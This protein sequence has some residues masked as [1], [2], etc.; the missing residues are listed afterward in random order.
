MPP[1]GKANGS[2]QGSK[3]WDAVEKT[4]MCWMWKAG[5]SPKGYGWVK[6][7]GKAR[8]AHR[9]AWELTY[10]PIPQRMNVLHRCDIPACVRPDHLFLGTQRD[11]ILDAIEKGRHQGRHNLPYSSGDTH[12]MAKLSMA[13]VLE[14]RRLHA[15]GLSIYKLAQRR[16]VSWTTMRDAVRGITWK[17]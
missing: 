15:Q 6:Y 14:A 1:R 16:S 13:I 4:D 3:F 17:N 8:R 7:R 10:G 11:N 2:Y 5:L 9:V 12:P